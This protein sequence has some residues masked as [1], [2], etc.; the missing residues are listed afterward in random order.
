[1][2]YFAVI[3]TN[4]LVSALLASLKSKDTPP[5]QVLDYIFDSVIIPVYNDEII[6]EYSEVLHRAKFGFP[7]SAITDVLQAIIS[8]GIESE[9]VASEDAACGDSDDVVFYEVALSVD[10]SFLVTGN[11][12]HFPTKPSIVTPA[13]MIE[14]IKTE[15]SEV[16]D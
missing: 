15:G 8:L 4:V 11:I 6:D 5:T 9:R 1:M 7:D 12:R 3:D 2:K 10:D 16:Q 14:I 13:R